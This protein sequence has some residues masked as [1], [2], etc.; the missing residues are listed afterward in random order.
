MDGNSSQES[1]L[2]PLIPKLHDAETD[3]MGIDPETG[4]NS[5]RD[6]SIREIDDSS[7]DD[8][9]SIEGRLLLDHERV[10][11]EKKLVRKLDSRLLPCIVAIFIMNYVSV[12]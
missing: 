2:A 3:N 9:H 4:S 1:L 7:G 8:Q 12:S 10:V 6:D 5:K 11:A